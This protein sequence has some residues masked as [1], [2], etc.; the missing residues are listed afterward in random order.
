MLSPASP[1]AAFLSAG[2][3]WCCWNLVLQWANINVF[4]RLIK[5][6]EGRLFWKECFSFAGENLPKPGFLEGIARR[7]LGRERR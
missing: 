1:A 5:K 6:W 2:L 7:M 3:G 4:L